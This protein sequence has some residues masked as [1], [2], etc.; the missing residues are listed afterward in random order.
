M[1]SCNL[2]EEVF[3]NELYLL[4][5][6][7]FIGHCEDDDVAPMLMDGWTAAQSSKILTVIAA[8]Q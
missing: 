2:S 4:T 6:V 1:T 7:T 8:P 5:S 3:R